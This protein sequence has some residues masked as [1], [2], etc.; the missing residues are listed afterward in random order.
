MKIKAVIEL[1]GEG[2]RNEYPC[3]KV[4]ITDKRRVVLFTGPKSGTL[5]SE[6]NIGDNT[7]STHESWA[8][9]MFVPFVGSIR[10][11]ND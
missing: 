9:D 1:D 4:S 7:G 6:T 2:E 8:E 10:L 3:L 5:L 11:S